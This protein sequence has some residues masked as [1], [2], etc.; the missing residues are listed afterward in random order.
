MTRAKEESMLQAEPQ[1][2]LLVAIEG[3]RSARRT[4]EEGR[5]LERESSRPRAGRSAILPIRARPDLCGIFQDSAIF[6]KRLFDARLEQ[7]ECRSATDEARTRNRVGTRANGS[8]ERAFR[9]KRTLFRASRERTSEVPAACTGSTF[10]RYCIRSEDLESERDA[11][12][13]SI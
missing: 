9:E 2:A 6:A 8:L 11:P 12:V 7:C 10:G 13:V 4:G 1:E 3:V 5:D